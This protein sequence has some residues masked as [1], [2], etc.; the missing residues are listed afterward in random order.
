MERPSGVCLDVRKRSAVLVAD[1]VEVGDLPDRR[2]RIARRELGARRDDEDVRIAHELHGLE[3][4][5][6]QGKIG[7]GQIELAPFDE[8]E[9]LDVVGGLCQR[10]LHLRPRLQEAAHDVRQDPLPDALEDADAELAGLTVAR[11]R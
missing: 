10:E 3:R 8:L 7:E 11:A 5:F 1:Q 4:A 6:D 2:R 9:Q